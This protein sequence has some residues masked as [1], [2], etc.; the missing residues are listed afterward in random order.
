M[1]RMRFEPT[2]EDWDGVLRLVRQIDSDRKGHVWASGKGPHDGYK[3]ECFA[4]DEAYWIRD[5][6]LAL[7]PALRGRIGITWLTWPK[8]ASTA[9]QEGENG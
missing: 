5:R 8:S 6:I 2:T 1:E 9:T 3:I 4:K 7:R